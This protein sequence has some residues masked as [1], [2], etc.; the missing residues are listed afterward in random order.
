MSAGAVVTNVVI[1]G[2]GP[3]G[4]VAAATLARAG[5]DVVVLDRPDTSRDRIGETLPG[6]AVR[7]LRRAGLP[8]P[9]DDGPHRRVRGSMSLWGGSVS[10]QDSLVDPDGPTWRLDRARFDADLRSAAAEAGARHIAGWF[11]DAH[12][13]EDDSWTVVT[14]EGQTLAARWLVDAT[15]R[16]S[17]VARALGQRRVSDAPLIAAWGVSAARAGTTDRTLVEAVDNGWWYAVRLPDDRALAAFHTDPRTAGQLARDAGLWREHLHRT[18]LIAREIDPGRFDG[19]TLR[20]ADARG[21]RLPAPAGQGWVAC[22]DAAISFEPL[23]S[24][25]L[26]NA[27]VTGEAAARVVLGGEAA[28][29]RAQLDRVR[30]VYAA[31]ASGYDAQLARSG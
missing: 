26:L 12:H 14:D 18:R 23:A 6:A 31:R 27:I 10:V 11:R 1:V 4:S 8:A 30:A 19:A 7:A 17:R 13:F 3:A 5:C 15:G 29:Y 9:T 2:A 20:L 21:G 28:A 16:R 24:Q 25:G 22:G